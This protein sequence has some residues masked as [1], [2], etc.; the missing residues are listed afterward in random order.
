MPTAVCDGIETRYEVVTGEDRAASDAALTELA[1]FVLGTC[2]AALLDTLRETLTVG[3][4]PNPLGRSRKDGQGAAPPPPARPGHRGI[5]A[6][7]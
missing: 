2:D 1:R 3:H 5:A 6:C 7:R 4:G